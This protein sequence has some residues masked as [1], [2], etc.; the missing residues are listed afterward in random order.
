[1]EQQERKKNSALE[2]RSPPRLQSAMVQLDRRE[3]NL[4]L[5]EFKL[6][7]GSVNY[8]ALF[9]IRSVDRLPALHRQDPAKAAVTV[10]AG[11]TMALETMNLKRPM[12]SAQ[13]A[14][15]A[16]EILDSSY[17]DNLALEDL[18]LFLQQLTRGKYVLYEGMDIPKF[19]EYFEQ[20]REERHVS[21]LRLREEA[22]MQYRALPVNPRLG[23][24][25]R[26]DWKPEIEDPSE[27]G[28][29]L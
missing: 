28:E 19:M 21:M 15:L 3:I 18:M 10:I 22:D 6:P 23:F 25:M 8:P 26:L 20:Y 12:T 24:N 16:E 7:D 1:M 17:E 4:I 29:D 5:R 2:T 9:Q 13:V 27:D 14:D 11:I